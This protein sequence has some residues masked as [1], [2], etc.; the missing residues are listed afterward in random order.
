MWVPK[1]HDQMRGHL[2]LP[3]VP[4]QLHGAVVLAA[5]VHS[6]GLLLP[7]LGADCLSHRLAN[8]RNP[9]QPQ[10]TRQDS[11]L[12]KPSQATGG[13]SYKPHHSLSP[14]FRLAQHKVHVSAFLKVMSFSQSLY[15]QRQCG[16][17][18]YSNSLKHTFTTEAAFSPIMPKTTIET[19]SI[20]W[21]P[22]SWTSL[23]LLTKFW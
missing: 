10:W 7:H 12:S 19:F 22:I 17:L 14:P 2:H 11:S 1:C 4:G 16:Y 9:Y 21:S 6:L 8:Q 20:K 5:H 15:L 18:T 23:K 13:L 3:R